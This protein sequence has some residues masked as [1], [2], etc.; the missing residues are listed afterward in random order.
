MDTLDYDDKKVLEYIGTGKTDGIFQLESAGMKS[1][2]KELKPNSLERYD[3]RNLSDIAPV[4][5][6]LFRSTSKGKTTPLQFHMT[7]RS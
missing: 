2:M 7:A 3:R 6:I 4:R 1:F 5:W